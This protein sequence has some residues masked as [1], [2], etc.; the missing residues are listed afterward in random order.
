LNSKK[1]ITNGSFADY[2]TV[3]ARTEQ[4]G[5]V[6]LLVER[7][8]GVETKIIKTSYSPAAGTAYITFDNVFVPYENTLGKENKGLQV[9]LSNF[10]HERWGM[11]TASIGSQRLIVEECL[12]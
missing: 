3:G 8:E 12:K 10:N 1:W 11:V 2:F 5:L 4:G 7:Q 6:V 9:I